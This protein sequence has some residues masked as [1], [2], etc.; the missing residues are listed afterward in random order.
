MNADLDKYKYSNC[1]IGFDFRSEFLFTDGSYVKN[2][3]IFF[4][5]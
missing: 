3:I 2:V 4:W 5:S 1:G